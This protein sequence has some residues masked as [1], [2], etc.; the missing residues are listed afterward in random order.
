MSNI[1]LRDYQI[2]GIKRIKEARGRQLFCLP[3]GSGKT[4]L[5]IF[6]K[7]YYPFLQKILICC[8]STIKLQWEQEIHRI[9][10]KDKTTILNGHYHKA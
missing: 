2:E 4:Y 10:P 7:S 5:S 6:M 1:T 8:P 9:F 3:A